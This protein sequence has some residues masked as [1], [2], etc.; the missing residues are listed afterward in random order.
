MVHAGK[1]R[2]NQRMH[3]PC[4]AGAIF[5]RYAPARRRSVMTFWQFLNQWW[6]LPYLVMLGLVAVFFVLQDAGLV[7]HV[8]QGEHDFDAD[9]APQLDHGGAHD[10]D[11]EVD[12]DIDHDLG[13][14]ASHDAADHDGDD[15]PGF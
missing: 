15:A 6:N 7:A 2:A 12:H 9:G 11:T 8:A 14:D 3:F 10:V 13:H 5:G 4:S 1:A